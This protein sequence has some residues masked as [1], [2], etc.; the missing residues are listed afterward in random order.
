MSALPKPPSRRP[1]KDA[2]RT[3]TV[4][5]LLISML[6]LFK[7]VNAQYSEDLMGVRMTVVEKAE[8]RL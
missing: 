4:L 1:V 5:M 3:C 6:A 7:C 2:R 8:D